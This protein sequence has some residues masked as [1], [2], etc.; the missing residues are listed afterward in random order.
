MMRCT[1][2]KALVGAVR[3]FVMLVDQRDS[4]VFLFDTTSIH[5]RGAAEWAQ[6]AR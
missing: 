3:G 1:A 2:L 5:A 6:S 4:E